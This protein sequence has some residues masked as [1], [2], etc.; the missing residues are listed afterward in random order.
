[1]LIAIDPDVFVASLRDVSCEQMLFQIYNHLELLRVAL[2]DSHKIVAEYYDFLEK[3][4][5][6]FEKHVAVQ[7]LQ[8][9]LLGDESITLPLPTRLLPS[10]QK[11]VTRYKCTTPLEPQLIGMA[12]NAKHLRLRLL[13]AGMG[14]SRLRHRGLNNP[15]VRRALKKE[16]PWLE[17]NFASERKEIFAPSSIMHEK[18][19]TFECLVAIKLQTLHPN[20]RCIETPEGVKALLKKQEDVDLYGY[21]QNCNTLVVWV[22]E[23]KL[24]REGNERDKP[25][26]SAEIAQLRLRM[27][28]ASQYE[29]SRTDLAGQT[30]QIKGLI[31]SNAEKFFDDLARQEAQKIGAEFWHAKLSSGWTT[32]HHWYI[33]QLTKYAE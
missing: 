18:A 1:M 21:E 33:R 27:Q 30:V 19:R 17:V 4:E 3:H 26:T 11:V 12:A 20:L 14:F 22:G 31:I 9:I 16:I 5:D 29:S 15:Q 2:D 7:L 24:R 10:V 23:C 8:I 28:K 25:I 32:D 13:L 6:R